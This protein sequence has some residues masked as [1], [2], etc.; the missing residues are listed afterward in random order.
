MTTGHPVWPAQ[1][2]LEECQKLAHPTTPTRLKIGFN[3]VHPV[4]PSL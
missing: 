1:R 4:H 2:N 3:A